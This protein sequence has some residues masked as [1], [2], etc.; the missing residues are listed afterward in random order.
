MKLD[1][2]SYF[3]TRLAAMGIKIKPMAAPSIG[4]PCTAVS[5]LPP[6]QREAVRIYDSEFLLSLFE[7]SES[8]A[9]STIVGPRE[10]NAQS[11][12]GETVLMKACRHVVEH[13]DR[14]WIVKALIDKGAD[15]MVCCESGKNVL[16]DLF[17]VARAGFDS[18][19]GAVCMEEAQSMHET[20]SHVIDAIRQKV[21]CGQLLRLLSPRSDEEILP[22]TT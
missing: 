10:A 12:W 1:P 13:K 16:H 20:A 17:W 19:S 21:G 7:G 15:P 9:K 3:Q 2:S 22:L 14:Q 8:V 18:E 11:L 5:T 6:K 4:V